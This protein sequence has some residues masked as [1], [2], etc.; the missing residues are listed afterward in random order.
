VVFERDKSVFTNSVINNWNA[1]PD[2]VVTSCSVSSF[3]RNIAKI[4]LSEY[5]LL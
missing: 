3:K 1:L 5:L 2:I 4:S